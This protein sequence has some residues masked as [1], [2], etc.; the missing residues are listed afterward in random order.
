MKFFSCNCFVH[1]GNAD[2]ICR[3]TFFAS[4]VVIRESESEKR[5]CRAS[6]VP[7]KAVLPIAEMDVRESFQ[8]LV[9]GT[10]LA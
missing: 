8:F 10:Y 9:Q 3:C 7:D 2:P 5:A 6:T 4:S 1:F